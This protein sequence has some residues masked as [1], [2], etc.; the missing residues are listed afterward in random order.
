MAAVE[1]AVLIGLCDGAIDS[2][3]YPTSYLTNKIGDQPDKLPVISWQHPRCGLCNAA[4]AH[5]VQVYCP[6]AASP[7]HR[8]LNVFACPGQQCSGQPESWRVLRSQCLESE[9]RTNPVVQPSGHAP[10]KEVPM[11]TTYWCDGTDDWGEEEGEGDGWDKA[12]NQAHMEGGDPDPDPEIL[13]PTGTSSE[14]DVSGKFQDLSLEVGEVEEEGEVLGNIPTYRPFYRPFYISVVE[15]TDLGDQSDLEHAESLLREYKQR[16]GVEEMGSSKGGGGEEKYEKGNPRHGDAA[17]SRFMKRISLCPEQVLRYSWHGSPLFL[18]DPPSDLPWIKP[19]CCHCGGIR[20]FEFQLMPAL[21]SLLQRT[22]AGAGRGSRSAV[23]MET[24]L[25]FG[26]V[27]VFTCRNSCWS[28]GSTSPV[29]EFIYLQ[30]DPD[31]K[32]FK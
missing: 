24:G 9:V 19:G 11:T 17:F 6:L 8:T 2:K 3:R 18:S 16:E 5:V 26:T 4:L 14:V 31:Q 21:V 1:E 30:A 23:E 7:Y 28:S 27:M 20:V 32:L 12:Q 29:E 13:L 25:E 10:V 15:E 22:D